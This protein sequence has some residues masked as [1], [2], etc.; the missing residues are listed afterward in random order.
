ML[1]PSG[2]GRLAESGSD[3]VKCP[4]LRLRHF[5]VGEDEEEEQQHDE[6][7]EDVRAAHFL[8]GWDEREERLARM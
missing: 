2:G 3:L 1:L 5:E 7:D 6:Y 4:A 8:R